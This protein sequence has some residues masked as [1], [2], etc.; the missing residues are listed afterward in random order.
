MIDDGIRAIR[1]SKSLCPYNRGK[2][3]WT[4]T[5]FVSSLVVFLNLTTSID[6][7][8]KLHDKTYLKQ[9]TLYLHIP[10]SSAHSPDIVRGFIYGRRRTYYKHLWQPSSPNTILKIGK[11][12]TGIRLGTILLRKRDPTPNTLIYLYKHDEFEHD[13]NNISDTMSLIEFYIAMY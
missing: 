9:P 7:N 5:G 11:I 2:L 10:P 4:N 6:K 13:A 8:D 3:K 1:N 12:G